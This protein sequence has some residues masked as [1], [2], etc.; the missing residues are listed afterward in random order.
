MALALTS[1]PAAAGVQ[2]EGLEALQ[3]GNFALAGELLT[4]H[5]LSNPDDLDTAMALGRALLLQGRPNEA[6]RVW[7][8]VAER[9]TDPELRALARYDM[10]HAAYRGGRLPQAQEHFSR[11]AEID[12]DLE[13]A[14]KNAQAVAQEIQARTQ[15]PEQQPN[16]ECDNPQQGQDGQQ[17]E[18]EQGSED[19]QQEGEQGE[20]RER[21][22]GEDQEQGQQGQQEQQPDDQGQRS[23]QQ[24]QEPSE[25]EI[26]PL[27]GQQGLEEEQGEG[28]P[29]QLSPAGLARQE[30]LDTLEEVQEGSPR[31]VI[32]GKSNDDQDW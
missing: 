17:Q 19:Q 21:E 27:D 9:S 1:P 2:Q 7:E 26:E 13:A 16:G 12:P 4:E 24:E 11:A 8:Q 32:D 23:E 10:G 25:G 18:G 30:A 31:V 28:A 15:D 3:A 22:Q 5:H 29:V 14:A 6:E 20:E